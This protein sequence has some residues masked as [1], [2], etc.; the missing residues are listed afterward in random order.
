MHPT[1]V[2]MSDCMCTQYW[3]FCCEICT[4]KSGYLLQPCVVQLNVVSKQ[5]VLINTMVAVWRSG[6]V[7][8]LD[9]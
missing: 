6:N 1:R 9:Q 7:V 5:S 3:M 8:G 4:A 2:F